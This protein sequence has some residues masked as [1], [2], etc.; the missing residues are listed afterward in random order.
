MTQP[1]HKN[2]APVEEHYSPEQLAE[3]FGVDTSTVYRWIKRGR[4]SP[5]R[6][7][8]RRIVR[9]PASAVNAFLEARTV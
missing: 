9:V 4:I 2:T 6:K 1:R 3:R 5:V 7:F 8:G